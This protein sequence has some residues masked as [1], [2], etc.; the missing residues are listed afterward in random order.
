MKYVIADAGLALEHGF[1]AIG[2]KTKAGLIILN[3][4]EVMI[5]PSLSGTL[6][7]RAAQINGKAMTAAEVD[8]ETNN[9]GWKYE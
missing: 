2:H 9:G 6:D 3:E 1:R 8:N 7:E 5:K 4:R